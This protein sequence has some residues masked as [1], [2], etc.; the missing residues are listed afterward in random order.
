MSQNLSLL[1]PFKKKFWNITGTYDILY[2]IR[3]LFDINPNSKMV[4]IS[5]ESNV[6]LF[7]SKWNSFSCM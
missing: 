6:T 1:I 3:L 2:I 5:M 4:D 7:K